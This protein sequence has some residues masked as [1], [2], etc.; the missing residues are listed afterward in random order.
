[1]VPSL[2]IFHEKKLHIECFLRQTELAGSGGNLG[3]RSCAIIIIIIIIISL[4]K[5]G[6]TLRTY[7]NNHIY[8]ISKVAFWKRKQQ[9]QQQDMHR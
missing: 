7:N 2:C 5:E 3:C 8:L 1:M 4:F 6:Y 9:Q